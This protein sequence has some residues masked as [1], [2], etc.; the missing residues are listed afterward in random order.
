MLANKSQAARARGR[1]EDGPAQQQVAR[2]LG[3][4]G[5]QARSGTTSSGG[6]GVTRVARCKRACTA[7]NGGSGE[8]CAGPRVC[9]QGA[10]YSSSRQ[11]AACV[12][13]PEGDAVLS[14]GAGSSNASASSKARQ[15]RGE[16]K[17]GS[18]RGRKGERRR[19][20]KGRKGKKGKRNGKKEYGKK[21][22]R[23]E[24]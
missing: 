8:S 23:R 20:R 5:H 13:V 10:G 4:H 18:Q 15:H 9:V 16:K 11:Q 12:C 3:V 1:D 6:R 2:R 21:R 24:K 19:E 14:A 17:R 7:S 22:V